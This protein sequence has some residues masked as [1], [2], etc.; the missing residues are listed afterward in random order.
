LVRH[1]ARTCGVDALC[2][3]GLGVLA[4]L[5][6]LHVCTAYRLDGRRI[7][8]PPAD[9]QALAACEPIYEELEGFSEPVDTVRRYADLP[10]AARR[11]VDLVAAHAGPVRRVCVGPSR[12]QMLDVPV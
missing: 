12:E 11:Y 8:T 4:G 3:T 10:A 2:L 5:E 6:S 7:E 1:T 9:A